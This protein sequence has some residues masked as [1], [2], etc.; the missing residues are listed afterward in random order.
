METSHSTRIAYSQ[1][2]IRAAI[3]TASNRVGSLSLM[4]FLKAWPKAKG[5]WYGLKPT[6]TWRAMTGFTYR[7]M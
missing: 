5:R 6:E 1:P 7:S 3:M 2:N 4:P